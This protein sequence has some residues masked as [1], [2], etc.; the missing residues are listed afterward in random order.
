MLPRLLAGLVALL[1]L[2]GLAWE[3]RPQP[4]NL[5]PS[6]LEKTCAYRG[7]WVPCFIVDEALQS[8]WDV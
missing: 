5:H 2:L 4:R 6:K 8:T 7:A 1:C 3:A